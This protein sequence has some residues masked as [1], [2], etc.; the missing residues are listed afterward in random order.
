MNVLNIF[1]LNSMYVF[2]HTRDISPSQLKVLHFNFLMA[3]GRQLIKQHVLDR[4]RACPRQNDQAAIRALDILDEEEERLIDEPSALQL[5]TLQRCAFCH[6]KEDRKSRIACAKCS[7]P[8]CNAHRS[9]QCRVCSTIAK[10]MYF[11]FL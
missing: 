7:K 2:K 9:Q 8:M 3:C 4:L 5:S 6:R 1:V 11:S 10:Y